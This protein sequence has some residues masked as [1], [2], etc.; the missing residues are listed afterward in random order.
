MNSELRQL[1]LDLLEHFYIW[2]GYGPTVI[3]A[4]SNSNGFILNLFQL[5]LNDKLRTASWVLNKFLLFAIHKKIKPTI[6]GFVPYVF[7]DKR[8]V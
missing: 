5:A 4:F 6:K 7:R 2:R 3:P 1:Y 8:K